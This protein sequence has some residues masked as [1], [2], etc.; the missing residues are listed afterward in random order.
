MAGGPY[1]QQS[2]QQR[3]K[4][5]MAKRLRILTSI[6]AQDA[7]SLAEQI[8]QICSATGRLAQQIAVRQVD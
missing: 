4:A 8:Q 6:G 3:A 7:L 2:R 1:R 5:K